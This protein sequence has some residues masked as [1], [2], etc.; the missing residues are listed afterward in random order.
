RKEGA[1]IHFDISLPLGE[2]A[3]FLAHMGARIISIAPDIILAPFGHIGD[4][5]LHYNM[6]FTQA[7]PQLATLKKRIQDEVYGEVTKRGGSLSAEH[8][9]GQER[10]VE[11]QR[12]KSP[13]E[14]ALMKK[15]KRAIDPDGIMNPGKI[16]D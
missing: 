14:I 3:D 1:G 10:K 4:G 11:L 15:I 2:I 8:G 13:V 6:C 7:S 9:I 5:N 12:Y 16:F